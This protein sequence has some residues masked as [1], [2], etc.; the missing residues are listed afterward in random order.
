MDDLLQ[1]P[2]FCEGFPLGD[3]CGSSSKL[4]FLLCSGVDGGNGTTTDVTLVV[5]MSNPLV[6]FL[7]TGCEG[8]EVCCG[9]GGGEEKW[10]CCFWPLRLEKAKGEESVRMDACQCPSG[11]ALTFF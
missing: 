5:R 8:D 10:N 6:R 9:G 1:V 4:S 7:V 11:F 2:V 3:D